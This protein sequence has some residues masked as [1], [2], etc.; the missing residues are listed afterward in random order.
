MVIPV[1]ESVVFV[2][3]LFSNIS[4]PSSPFELVELRYIDF[5]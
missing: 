5:K 3:G 2:C 4:P 1:P